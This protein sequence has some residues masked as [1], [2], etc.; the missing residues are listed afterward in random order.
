M[1]KHLAEEF[2]RIDIQVIK[3]FQEQGASENIILALISELE[4]LFITL[5]PLPEGY[6]VESN[7]YYR[8]YVITIMEAFTDN[9]VIMRYMILGKT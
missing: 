9:D 4:K 1:T 3:E 6:S 8:Q 7:G 5:I 2:A